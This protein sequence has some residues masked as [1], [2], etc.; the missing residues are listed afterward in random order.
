MDRVD[1][2]DIPDG[3]D[4]TETGDPASYLVISAWSTASARSM[5]SAVRAPHPVKPLRETAFLL[6]IG[7]QTRNLTL[8]QR[9][10]HPD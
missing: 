9:T 3:V 4:G 10:G 8:Q 5:G 1:K 2:M 6:E 7:R